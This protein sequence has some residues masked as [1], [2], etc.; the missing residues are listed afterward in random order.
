MGRAPN[1]AHMAI[2]MLPDEVYHLKLE[3]GSPNNLTEVVI[4]FYASMLT[5]SKK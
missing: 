5:M 2:L 3:Y 4:I 1:I